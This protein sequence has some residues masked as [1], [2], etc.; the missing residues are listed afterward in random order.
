MTAYRGPVFDMAVKQF[1]VIA[2]YLCIPQDARARLLMPKRAVTVSCPIHRDDGTMAVFEGYRVQHHLTLGPTKGGTRFAASV[3]L[4]EVAA[5]AIW[6]SWKC[7]LVGLPYGGA[8]GGINVDPSSL[9]KRELEVLSRRYMQEM[10]PFVGPHTDVMAPDMG[11]NEQIMAWFMDTYSMYQGQTVTEIVT[12]KPVSAGGTLGRREAT[13]RGVAHLVHRAADEL[14]IRLS[15]ATAVVQGFGNVGSIAALELHNMGVKVIAVSDHTGALYRPAGLDI[16]QLVRHAASRGSLNGYSS[17]LALDSMEMLTLQCDVL[18]PAAVERV[19]NGK[20]AGNLRC[21]ILAEGANGPTTPEADRVLEKRQK[22]IF[23]IPDIL[24]NS[25]GVVVSYFEWVQD[26]QR[27]FWE[28]EEVMRR[29]Y[30][31]LD[32]AF[33]RVLSRSR[34]DKIFNRSAAMAIGVERVRGAKDTRGLFP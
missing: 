10:I 24:C 6:M 2:D 11:T 33:E 1:E 23:V 21:R 34:R 28:E 7:A 4:G 3:D 20:I 18:V 8:K 14:K 5:L 26:L 17:E 13:G 15:G 22:E 16:P 25:G 9:S 12:G 32:R 19:I 30:Q 29:E 31:V 27:L